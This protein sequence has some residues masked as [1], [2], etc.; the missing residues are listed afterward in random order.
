MMAECRAC[1]AD[2]SRARRERLNAG[3]P[4]EWKQKTKDMVAYKKAWREAHPG[5]MTAYK[6][7]WWEKNKD[8]LK[9]RSAVRYAMKT[10]KLV[11]QPC[12]VCGEVEVHAHHPDYSMPLDVVW[13]CAIHHREVHGMNK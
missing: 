6:K 4:P 10:G 7:K 2:Y 11:K 1:V 5:A 3:R 12:F 8:K 13:L 9:V